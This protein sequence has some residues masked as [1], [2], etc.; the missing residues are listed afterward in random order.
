MKQ[1]MSVLVSSLTN[2]WL[3]PPE[4]IE[5]AREVMDGIIQLDP[6]SSDIANRLV[7]ALV[8]FT[9]NEDGLS[10]PWYG[11]I[12]LNC[13]YGK[14][15]NKSNQE[16]WARKMLHE[17]T[18]GHFSEGV[19]LSRCTP[20]YKWWDFLF[21]DVRPTVCITRDRIAFIRPEWVQE[22]GSIVY[23]KG[24]P[25]RSKAA[26]SFWYIGEDDRRFIQ[27]FRKFGRVIP[28]NCIHVQNQYH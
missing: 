7:K 24:Q 26:T 27:V 8:Y 4:Y 23:P 13:P 11:N 10:L 1:E 14:T 3:T 28:G 12:F 21:N 19:F 16:I 18:L 17:Y 5:A 25:K 9:E 15:K 20:G 6:A 22:D 2:E